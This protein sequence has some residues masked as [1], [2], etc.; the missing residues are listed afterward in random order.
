MSAA[1]N[2][3]LGADEERFRDEARAWLDAHVEPTPEFDSFDEEFAWG[4]RW[5]ARLAED[6]WVGI[7]WPVEYGGRAATPLQVAIFNM[8]YARSRAPQPVNR[9]GVNL[10]GP[11]LLTHGDGAQRSRWLPGILSADEIWCQLFSEPGAGSDLAGLSTRATPADDGWVLDGQKVWTSYAQHSR[12]GIALVRS[13]P[14]APRHH[15]ISCM[16]V[17]MQSP[18]IEVRPL[19]TMTGEAEFNEVFLDEVFVPGDQVIG[20][21]HAGWSVANTTLAHERGTTF[22]FKE[23]VVHEVYLDQLLHLAAAEGSFDDPLVADQLVDAYVKLRVLRLHNWRTMTR[24]ARGI[25]PGPES[26][27]VKL[28]WTDMTQQL[29]DAALSVVGDAS[30]LWAG[31]DG[32]PGR[33]RWQRQW[34]WSKASSIAGGT[35][36]IQRTIIGDRILGLPR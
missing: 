34:L 32:D 2:L 11:T 21:V 1:V 27:V 13:D 5:Q 6:R 25:E 3:T 14:D 4:R 17:D 30:P 7:H 33:G 18:G 36:E 22:P 8:E 9:T 19:V 31:A 10:V 26:S 23:Q 20:E 12:W 28:A 29:S 15:G 16:A 35:S 24:L